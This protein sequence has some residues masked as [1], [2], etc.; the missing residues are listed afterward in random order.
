MIPG[1]HMMAL[2]GRPPVFTAGAIVSH[3]DRIMVIKEAFAVLAVVVFGFS[4]RSGPASLHGHGIPSLI[5]AIVERVG[6]RARPAGDR[7]L[8]SS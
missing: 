4:R 8:H 3:D 6:Q 2:Y 1:R 7:D 5:P